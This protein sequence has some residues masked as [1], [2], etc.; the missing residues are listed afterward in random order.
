VVS[1]E[2]NKTLATW[3]MSSVAWLKAASLACEGLVKPESLRT[4]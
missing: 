2:V 4:N 3:A 1:R